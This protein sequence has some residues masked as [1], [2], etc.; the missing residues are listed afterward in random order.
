MTRKTITPDDRLRQDNER[1]RRNSDLLKAQIAVALKA[2]GGEMLG[3]YVIERPHV[4]WRV[5]VVGSEDCLS[6]HDSLV[7]ARAAVRRYQAGDK[8][9]SPT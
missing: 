9:H 5:R 2:S 4:R 3:N 6:C 7:Q 1:L 8:R